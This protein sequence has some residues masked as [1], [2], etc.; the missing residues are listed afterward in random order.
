MSY[1]EELKKLAEKQRRRDKYKEYLERLKSN[2]SKYPAEQEKQ[3]PQVP[4]GNSKSDIS[5]IP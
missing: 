3:R 1:S 2:D 5:L 4:T